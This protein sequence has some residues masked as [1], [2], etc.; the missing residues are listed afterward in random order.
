MNGDTSKNQ[1]ISTD[2]FSKQLICVAGYLVIFSTTMIK[3][4]KN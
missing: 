3:V 1:H 2:S 4:L